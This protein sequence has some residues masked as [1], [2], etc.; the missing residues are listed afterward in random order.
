MLLKG[1]RRKKEF[2]RTGFSMLGTHHSPSIATHGIYC[3]D[4]VTIMV[5]S[6]KS[7]S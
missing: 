7:S 6:M 1:K 3:V 4:T 5:P 2:K